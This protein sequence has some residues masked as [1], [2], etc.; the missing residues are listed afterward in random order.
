MIFGFA[1][2][3]FFSIVFCLLKAKIGFEKRVQ[4]TSYLKNGFKKRSFY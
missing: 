4:P 3:C 2:K 1:N